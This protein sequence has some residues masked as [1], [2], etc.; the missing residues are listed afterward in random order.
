MCIRHLVFSFCNNEARPVA[1]LQ[2]AP[3]SASLIAALGTPQVL[4]TLWFSASLVEEVSRTDSNSL[5][6]YVCQTYLRVAILT[7]YQSWLA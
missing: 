4:A 3:E 7:F 2:D 6:T 1:A 5:K